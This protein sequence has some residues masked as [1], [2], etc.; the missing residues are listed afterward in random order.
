MYSV[1]IAYLLWV[2]SGFGMLGFHRFYLGKFPTGLLWMCSFGLFFMG[3]IY[4]FFTL[5]RQVKEANLRK[6]LFDQIRRQFSGQ[7]SASP[8]GNRGWHYAKDAEFRIVGE[9]EAPK[10]RP[11]QVILK[12]A[13]ENKGI[14]TVSEVALG[15]D[16][17]M[18]EAKKLLEAMVTKGFAELR[19]RR[20]GTLVYVLP[21]MVDKDEPLENF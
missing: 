12:L 3:A 17:P 2:L 21:D 16:I 1:F 9:K 15:A 11:E 13:R 8:A 7:T 20:T 18:E 14:L 10:E 6:E 4:D 5:P 19:V